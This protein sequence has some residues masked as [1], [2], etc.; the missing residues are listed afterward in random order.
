MAYREAPGKSYVEKLKRKGC[1]FISTGL[2]EELDNQLR[3]LGVPAGMIT[4]HAAPIPE[5]RPDTDPQALYVGYPSL[6]DTSEY[7]ADE[8]KIEVSVRSLQLPSA[9]VSVQSLLF[10]FNP[11][12]AY[13]E[14][15][16][17][18]AAAEARKTFLEKAFLLH[19]EF[20]KPD[21]SRIRTE[22]MSRHLYDLFRMMHTDIGEQALSDH[23]LYDRLIRHREWYSR[24]SWVD[25]R[26]LGHETLSFL[27][28][29]EVMEDYR[30]DYQTMQ[31]QM[32]YEETAPFDE[33]IRQLKLLQGKFRLKYERKAL[34]EIIDDALK[35]LQASGLSGKTDG[36]F[37]ETDVVYDPGS[38]VPGG[39]GDKRVIYKVVFLYQNEQLIFERIAAIV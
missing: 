4:I 34:G 12:P 7:I 10:R 38:Y 20:G 18:V 26:S 5:D 9:T 28:A 36:N 8:V 37:Y 19:E 3:E 22:R 32:I 15:P 39:T 13:A 35:Q 31:E 17:Q 21:R 23:A 16:F 1:L 29:A 27:P 33:L 14:I 2:M 25:Y 11:R 6:Y 24:I 30:R